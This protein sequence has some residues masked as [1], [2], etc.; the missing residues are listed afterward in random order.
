[1]AHNYGL[2]EK[3]GILTMLP[4]DYDVALGNIGS[5]FGLTDPSIFINQPIDTPVFKTTVD[6][7]PMLRVL[8][9]NEEGIR[10]YHKYLD[11]LVTIWIDSGNMAS[12]IQ[13]LAA[14]IRPWVERET[15]SIYSFEEHLQAVESI[16]KFTAY[17]GQSI[18]G[19]LNGTIPST[20]ESQNAQAELLPDYSNYSPPH[21]GIMK[22]LLPEYEGDEVSMG[23]LLGVLPQA[24]ENLHESLS[25]PA[26]LGLI[27]W[28]QLLTMEKPE[29]GGESSLS[30]VPKEDLIAAVMPY[31]IIALKLLLTAVA[32]PVVLL[33]GLRFIR[34]RKEKRGGVTHV[35]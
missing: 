14:M 15:I 2:Y 13:R 35:V 29:S 6:E 3:D 25:L 27:D 23:A 17:R 7:R 10:L 16:Q 9:E 22:I 20:W 24:N 1:M 26:L 31:P 11:E 28:G 5:E 4:W 21:S 8:L 33:L 30:K 34:R 19:Q 12:E 32:V 18:R